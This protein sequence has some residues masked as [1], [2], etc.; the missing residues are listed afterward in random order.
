MSESVEKV[1]SLTGG[2]RAFETS[3]F[4]EKVDK[5][6]YCLNVNSFDEDKAFNHIEVSWILS[7]ITYY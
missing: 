6:F 3:A 7:L 1:F 5:S 2:S 4:V